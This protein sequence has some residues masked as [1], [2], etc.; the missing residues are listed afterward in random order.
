MRR[1]RCPALGCQVQTFRGQVAGVLERCQRRI[2]RLT[3]Q[4]S[5][6]ARELAGRA[7]AGL[8]AAVGVVVSRDTAL[9]V[10]LKIPLPGAAV[11]RMVGIDDFALRR[12]LVCAT[13]LIDAE[14]G[15]PC[16]C[17]SWPGHGRG[18]GMVA[19][20]SRDRGPVP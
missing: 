19:R 17:R 12:G 1:M 5:A 4:V 8:L 9:R 18:R 10:L 13:V 11:P 7:S 20:P 16:R 14:T 15:P 2:S 3:A 6:V